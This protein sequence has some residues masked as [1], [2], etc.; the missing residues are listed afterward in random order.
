[1]VVGAI[2]SYDEH[3][4]VYDSN[5]TNNS[6]PNG[7]GGIYFAEISTRNSVVSNCIFI[8]NAVLTSSG[9]IHNNGGDN[10]AI[11]D[12]T[13]INNSANYG[14]AI[15][16]RGTNGVLCGNNLTVSRCIFINNS[17]NGF[18]G[19]AILSGSPSGG[20]SNVTVS[21]CIFINNSAVAGPAGAIY[22]YGGS[23]VNVSKCIFTNNS[24][25]SFCG[26]I[27]N[28]VAITWVFG[29]VMSG[30]SANISGQMIYNNGTIGILNL[31]YLDN[32]T[33]RVYNGSNVFLYA[34]LVDNM[35]NTVTGQNVS[36]YLNGTLVGT[37]ESLE[38]E[39]NLTYVIFGDDGDLFPVNGSYDGIG[40]FPILLYEG[41]LRI[42][43]ITTNTTINV[44]NIV[45]I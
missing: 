35:G 30:N 31:T 24:A 33:K 4:T 9:A 8:N 44:S 37:V 6:V 11:S 28:E 3:M 15:Y 7:S 36:F 13:F 26:A 27:F 25:S 39:A 42:V 43:K 1:M 38:G 41:Q 12:C 45:I 5:F 23:N 21:E 20:G 10:I 17:A 2:Y 32:S 40:G 19:G 29:N 14:G 34:I 16:N 22:I 18:G